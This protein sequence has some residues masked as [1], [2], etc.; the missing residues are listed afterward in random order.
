MAPGHL[1]CCAFALF[2]QLLRQGDQVVATEHLLFKRFRR[3]P[4]GIAAQQNVGATAGHI[5]R[6][7]HRAAPPRLGDNQRLAPVVLGV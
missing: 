5:G 2:Q 1:A 4:F 3:H 7:R 6:N